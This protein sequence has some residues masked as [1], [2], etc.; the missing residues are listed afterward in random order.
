[1]K[2]GSKCVVF[3]EGKA[4][5]WASRKWWTIDIRKNE[6]V[7]IPENLDYKDIRTSVILSDFFFNL[8][9]FDPSIFAN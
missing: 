3:R 9:I 4:S 2:T 6:S 7:T 1:M 5:S 8:I